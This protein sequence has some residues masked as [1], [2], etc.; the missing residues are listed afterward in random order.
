[1]CTTTTVDL[2]PADACLDPPTRELLLRPGLTSAETETL[3]RELF[4]GAG[5][6]QPPAGVTCL[7]SRLLLRSSA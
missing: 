5:V 2:G 3:A 1:M 6:A 4:A 7:C